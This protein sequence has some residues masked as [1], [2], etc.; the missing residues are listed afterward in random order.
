MAAAT[1]TIKSVHYCYPISLE[2]VSMDTQ[3]SVLKE[4][5]TTASVITARKTG[6]KTRIP[7]VNMKFSEYRAAPGCNYSTLKNMAISPLHYRHA[8]ENPPDETP[9]MLMGKATH[10]AVFEPKRFQLE[11]AVW[12]DSRRTNAYKEFAEECQTQGRSV[13]TDSEYQGVLAIRDS[14]RS[15]PVVAQLLEK[16][17]S[18]TSLFW[19]NPQTGIE[20][21][22]RLDWIAAERAILDLKTTMSIDESWFS[23]QAW[24]MKYFHQ[25]A[26]Y[27]EGY[28]VSSGRGTILPFG[29]I[30]VERK[31][32]HACRL[33]WLD[34]DSLERAHNEYLSWLE[35]VRTCTE[36]GVWPGPIPV[37]TELKAPGWAMVND[38]AIDFEGVDDSEDLQAG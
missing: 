8:L 32:P 23:K 6:S 16:G 12:S 34:D 20:C 38:D 31:P 26:M 14:V 15:I 2:G 5:I 22:G 29:I 27:R 4:P 30:A 19:R 36:N 24:K 9:A 37:E 1:K 25:A 7:G 33:F 10:T 17:R 18:E 21:K 13:L 3:S 11:Y 35:L 28:A